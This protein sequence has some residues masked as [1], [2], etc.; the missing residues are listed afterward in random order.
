MGVVSPVLL[1]QIRICMTT[2][3]PKLTLAADSQIKNINAE[4]LW[5]YF[6]SR[7]RFFVYLGVS[8]LG[9][10]VSLFFRCCPLAMIV[11]LV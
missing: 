2:F 1:V 9:F 5:L 7:C 3:S 8:F 10:L 11:L 4:F 6:N